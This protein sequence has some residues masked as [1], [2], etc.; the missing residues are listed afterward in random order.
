VKLPANETKPMEPP[1]PARRHPAIAVIF[2]TVEATRAALIEAGD[3]V[4]RL[5]G[6]LTLVV[7]QVVPIA[8]PLT[9][10]PVRIDWSL[11]RFQDLAGSSRV[12]TTVQLCL[13]RDRS[14]ALRVA[15][16]PNSVVVLGGRKRWWPTGETRMAASLR[17][18]GHQVIFKGVE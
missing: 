1:D 7:P 11:P 10:P 14:D 9:R 8:H 17:K 16:L 2:T 5:G 18:A 13:C 12:E 3:M 4:R 15:L 6:R